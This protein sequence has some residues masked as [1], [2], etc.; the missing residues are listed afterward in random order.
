MPSDLFFLF[1]FSNPSP[2]LRLRYGNH[3]AEYLGDFSR[4][5]S[6]LAKAFFR[7]FSHC[8]D[9]S[10]SSSAVTAAR[11]MLPKAGKRK[12]NKREKDQKSGDALPAH[13]ARMRAGDDE[14]NFH[15]LF[16]ADR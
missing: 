15:F 5:L 9:S 16:P 13:S 10:S 7:F 11:K 8:S 6:A 2:R 12:E 1:F 14:R 4:G 3:L